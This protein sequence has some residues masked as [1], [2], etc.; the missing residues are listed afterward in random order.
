MNHFSQKSMSLLLSVAVLVGTLFTGTAATAAP[1]APSPT[2]VPGTPYDENGV[3]DVTVPHVIINQ[4]YG[5]GL[6]ADIG[7]EYFTHGFIEL[8]NPTNIDI[9]LNGWSIHYADRGS[10]AISG[11]TGDWMK[12][13]LDSAAVIKAHSSYLITGAPTGATPPPKIDLSISD[14]QWSDRYIN[15]KGL[16]VVLTSNSADLI[17]KNP[18]LTKSAAYVDMLGTAANETKNETDIDGYE[19]IQYSNSYPKGDGGPSKKKALRRV[20]FIDTDNNAADFVPVNYEDAIKLANSALLASIKPRKG[21][22]NAWFVPLGISNITLPAA[23]I[24]TA[25]S[26]SVAGSVYGGHSPYDISVSG[27]PAGLSYSNGKIIGSPSVGTSGTVTAVLQVTDSQSVSVSKALTLAVAQAIDNLVITSTSLPTATIGQPYLV[28]VSVTGG[29][30]PLTFTATGLPSGLTIDAAT[31]LITGIPAEGKAGTI[32]VKVTVTDNAS[33]VKTADLPL[34]VSPAVINYV[35]TLNVTK[36]GGYSVGTTNADGG[37]AEIVKFNKDNG[38]FYLVNGSTTPPTLDIVSLTTSSTLT[39]DKSINVQ[40]LSERGGNFTYGDL[41]SVDINTTVKRISVSVQEKDYSKPGKI[42]VLDYEGNLIKSYN[43]GVQPDMIKTTPDGRYILTADEGEPRLGSGNGIVDPEGSITIVDTVTDSVSL[44][45]FNNPAVIDDDVHVRGPAGADG[46]ITTKGTK[47][48]AIRDF[49]PEYIALSGDYKKAYVSLQENNAIATIDIVNKVVVS[50]KSLGFKDFNQTKNVLDLVKDG[51]IKLENVPF[52]GMYMPDGIAT[53]TI[54]GKTYLFTANEG[55]ATEWPVEK[56]FTRTSA[57]TVG[58]IKGKLDPDS[59]AAKFLADK[60]KIYDKVEV[61]SDMGTDSIYM[62]GGRSF[63]IWDIDT[64]SQIYDSGSDFERITADRHA[65]YFN[66][67]H[68]NL[69]LDSRSSKKGPEPEDIKTGKVGSR[70]FAFVGLERIGGIMTYDVTDPANATFANYINTR[71]FNSSNVLGTDTGPEGIDFIPAVDSPTGLPLLL[72]AYE[73]GG[74]VAVL[75]LNVTKVELDKKVISTKVGNASTKIIPTVTPVGGGAATVTWTSSDKAVATVD[76]NGNVTPVSA[77]KATITAL[78]ADGYGEAQAN[79]TVTAATNGSGPGAGN[80]GTGNSGNGNTETPKPPVTSGEVTKAVV[81]IKATKDKSG[82]A[83]AT[84]TA[85]QIAEIL[86]ALNKAAANGKTAILELK[87]IGTGDA[88]Q[89]NIHIAGDSLAQ[90]IAS[91]VSE[92]AL[93]GSI[94]SVTLDKTALSSVL[95][96]SGKDEVIIT[97]KKTDASLVTKDL[98]QASKDAIA[99]AIGTKPVFDLTVKAGGKQITTFGGG[100]VTVSAPYTPSASEDV[101]AIVIYY[102]SDLGELIMVP[103]GV[104]DS[105]TGKVTFNVKH[106]SK[107]AVGYNKLSFGDTGSS[108]AKDF[109]TY[110]SARNIIGGVGDNKF[111]PTNR[112]TRADITVILAR[113]AGADLNKYT[114]SSFSDVDTG[115]YYSKSVEWAVEQGIASGIGSGLYNPKAYVTREQLVTMIARY[116]AVMKFKLPNHV[117]A[118]SFS[119]QSKV[120]AYAVSALK[121]VQQAGIISGKASAGQS[122]IFFAPKDNATR[123][124]AA[125]ILATLMQIMNK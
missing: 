14:K 81:E 112:I 25:Y 20:N 44:V 2:A 41:T 84:F 67:G 122:G 5:A 55:D 123:E 50:V 43:A 92:V 7:N 120:P 80:P 91:Q 11:P 22:D 28:N 116:A 35:D 30:A 100:W 62:Y 36:I 105:A 114:G 121:A 104:Y 74:T 6:V 103:N 124:E 102:I 110:L 38:K 54:N 72:V 125:K 115:A 57:T 73:V 16:K 64:W 109:I 101:H 8:Y 49:E 66:A 65:Q 26:Y 111:A 31:G 108:F 4:V 86:E 107:Y 32:K 76:V 82:A 33:F 119:D 117:E 13:T 113:M 42:L 88:T 79:V 17:G 40:E 21:A 48:D 34:T 94:G 52:K 9:S 96:A 24:G 60:A 75:Q 89:T 83:E 27:L 56:P 29:N 58:A 63:S 97:I 93:D 95:A 53:H 39:K 45:K 68:N 59:E 37:V 61:L 85:K 118:I 99:A 106:F 23:A 3:Y 10:N 12:L 90:I 51:A 19:G 71:E 1:T 78:S 70:T 18:F 47:A 87:A 98:S 69:E 15:N 46:M 77:G